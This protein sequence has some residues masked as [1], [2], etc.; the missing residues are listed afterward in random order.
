MGGMGK[1][2]TGVGTGGPKKH[3]LRASVFTCTAIRCG[4]AMFRVIK[5]DP[6]CYEAF[7]KK[8]TAC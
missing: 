5:G 3:N 2:L 6:K 7:C 8:V 1:K 4:A